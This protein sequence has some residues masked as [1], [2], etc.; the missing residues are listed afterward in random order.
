VASRLAIQTLEQRAINEVL[1]ATTNSE[2]LPDPGEWV[3]ATTLAANQSVYD[4]RKAAGTDMGTT[5]VLALIIGDMVTIG[6]VGDSRAYLLTENGIIQI[7][8]DHSLVERLVATGQI[9]RE[10]AAYHPQR[11]VIYRVIGDK[12]EVEPD[13]FRQRLAP[14]E[15]LLLCSYGVPLP[16]R[17]RLVID[18]SKQPTWP[19]EWIT[20]PSWLWKQQNNEG[21]RRSGQST[22]GTYETGVCCPDP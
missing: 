12:L 21:E 3:T 4:Q 7:T 8:T 5:L 14:G 9:T 15:A 22:G 20:S 16:A 10:E 11:N 17:K 1:S 6:N 19:V 13:V 18:W 2:P